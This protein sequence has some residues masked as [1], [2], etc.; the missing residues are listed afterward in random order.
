MTYTVEFDSVKHPGTVCSTEYDT[1]SEAIAICLIH[2]EHGK[3]PRLLVNDVYG[4]FRAF[5]MCANKW[6][7]QPKLE[8]CFSFEPT[9]IYKSLSC[10]WAEDCG[11]RYAS[12]RRG[13]RA[14]MSA[15]RRFAAHLDGHVNYRAQKEAA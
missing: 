4:S 6:A 10:R 13:Y 8:W 15:M 11:V 14:S 7:K 1:M 3:F 9:G 2:R 12:H 5:L